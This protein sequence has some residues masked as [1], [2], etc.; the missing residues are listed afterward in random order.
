ML[1]NE[2]GDAASKEFNYFVTS[3]MS[4]FTAFTAWQTLKNQ[5]YIFDRRKKI[6]QIEKG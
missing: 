2:P 3:F 1:K 6:R 4:A 5:Y